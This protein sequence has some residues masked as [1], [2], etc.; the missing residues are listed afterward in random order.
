MTRVAVLLRRH[1][2]RA[3]GQP[4]LRHAG[5]RGAA[6]GRLRGRRRS[7]SAHDLGAVIAALDAAAGRGV[8]RAARPLRRGWRDPGRARLAGHPLHPFR[9]ARLGAG[10][11]QGRRPRRCSPPPGLPV[12]RG[13]VVDDR[14]SWKPPT[15]CRCPTWS[16]RSNEGSSVG[17]EIIRATATTAAP[18][19][20]A[21]GASAR[22]ALVEEYIPG[23]ELTV[24]VMGDRA[25]AVTEI[26]AEAGSFYDY[27]SQIRRRR[28]APRHPGARASRTST[29]QALDVALAAHRALGC[30]GATRADFR[31]DDTAGEP[32]RLVLLEVNTQPGLT[33]TSLLPEQAAHRRHELP[34][35]LRLDG[36]ERRMPRVARR[37]A[38]RASTTGP[39]RLQ[40]AAAPADARLL[41]AGRLGRRSAWLVVLL[42]GW[43]LV[44]SRATA[45]ARVA[46][47]RERLGR[48]DRRLPGCA[49]TDIRIEGRAN[50]PE[51]LLRAALGVTPGDPILGFSVAQARA[52]HRDTV[53]GRARHCRAAA[54]RHHR[55]DPAGAAAVRHLAEP[56]Q[57][58]ADRPRRP[59][60]RGPERARSLRQPAAG[61]RRR[62]A[63]RARR[64]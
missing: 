30:R 8:Q 59:G 1:L 61:R 9:R 54:A 33:P 52:A 13:R 55:G 15:R 3:R 49:C 20:R 12:A 38:Q 19:S 7:R 10:H 27:E 17:V 14:T 63:G 26:V 36:G 34:G 45:A 51:P 50:T 35:A 58:R 60:R 32:G 64:R 39:R 57:V 43:S 41:R 56:G 24:G 48:C 6:R 4:L 62:R 5:D 16:S 47:L 53:L 44:R 18:R 2:R 21:A 22:T 28:L 37:P 25:L 40:A 46:T 11:G 42:G 29:R 31:Y 23:R